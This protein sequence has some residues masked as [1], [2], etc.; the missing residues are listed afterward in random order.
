MCIYLRAPAVRQITCAGS[1][2]GSGRVAG[3]SGAVGSG[4]AEDDTARENGAYANE[5]RGA[6]FYPPCVMRASASSSQ[7]G[8]LTR[9]LSL[10]EVVG[11]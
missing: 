2:L 6:L 9:P 1:R 3:G 4:I 5:V 11:A 7:T 8:T 10:C